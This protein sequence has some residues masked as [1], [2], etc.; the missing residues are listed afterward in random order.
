VIHTVGPRWN[1]GRSGEASLLA[2]CYRNSLALALQHGAQSIAF[3]AI[4]TGVY[5]YPLRDAMQ[6]CIRTILDHRAE[7]PIPS[8][9]ILATFGAEATRI[10]QET[11]AALSA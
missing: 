4:S 5:G 10:A 11:L 6:V 7:H 8:R 1:G 3:P 2:S 9:I